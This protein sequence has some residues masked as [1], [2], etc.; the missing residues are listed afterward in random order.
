M[1]SAQEAILREL[2]KLACFR[3]RST[4]ILH[5]EFRQH[6]LST[7]SLYNFH[8]LRQRRVDEKMSSSGITISSNDIDWTSQLPLQ[9][10]TMTLYI[11]TSSVG[12]I[13]G[14]RGS[15]IA[16]I[17][18]QAQTLSSGNT[19]PV[20]VSIVGHNQKQQP[21]QPPPPPQ[22]PTEDDKAEVSQTDSASPS[23]DAQATTT[24]S[25]SSIVPYTYTE[26]DWSSPE[27][28]PVVVKADPAAALYVG[29]QLEGMTTLQDSIIDLPIGRQKHAAIIGKRGL[30]VM[31]LSAS[32]NC[33]IMVPPR[34]LKHDFIQLEGQLDNCIQCLQGL[35]ALFPGTNNSNSTETH[36]S[37]STNT[38][39]NDFAH[40]TSIVMQH[41]PPQTK[42]RS[43][44][45]KTDTIIKK[46]KQEENWLLT[47]M[48]QSDEQVTIAIGMLQKWSE[49]AKTPMS[50]SSNGGR[51]G[52]GGRG[53]GRG[54][55]RG[56][57]GG[58]GN[59]HQ[60]RKNSE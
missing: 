19:A 37:K 16:Q 12:A 22:Q 59:Y 9:Q 42:L 5:C 49:N 27:W 8:S 34:E 1:F 60:A 46:K 54:R 50:N 57:G 4:R 51:G 55:G 3:F 15:T 26:L 20:R 36:P 33:R 21:Q 2:E 6:F 58:R 30:T 11:P 32:S 47:V 45:R 29:Q 48:G 23:A 24:S 13:I 25:S 41:L 31:N 44:G 18:R 17:Q 40:Q 52:R 28:T 38:Q 43:I 14:R 56:R 53:P 10:L 35:A 7:Q 39:P